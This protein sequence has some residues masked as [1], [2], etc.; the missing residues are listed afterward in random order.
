[1]MGSMLKEDLVVLFD[2]IE[3]PRIERSKKYPIGEIIF[4]V[5]FAALLGVES[6]RGTALLGSERID[7]LRK[8]FPF[9]NG[10]P[11]HQTI[12]RVFSI[13]KPKSFEQFFNAWSANL[14]GSNNGK[15]I[16]FDGKCLRGSYDKN[17]GQK[18]LHILNACAVEN[19]ITLA[20]IEVDEKTN[21]ITAVPDMI[22]A[23]NI[24]GAMISVDALNTQKNIAEK[25]ID[26]GAN[27]TLALKGNHKNLNEDVSLLFDTTEIDLLEKKDEHFEGCEKEHG[28]ITTRIYDVIPVD[29]NNL[30]LSLNWKGLKSV[31]RVKT[32]TLKNEKETSETRY[33]LL[34]YNGAK[35]FAKAARGHWGIENKLHWS[36]DVVYSEDESRK[37]AD[38]APRNYSLIRKFALNICRTFK[39]KLSVP[40]FHIKNASNFDFFHSVLLRSGFKPLAV[41]T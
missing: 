3:D 13:L 26:S 6:W 28:R 7:L 31:G 34:S 14:H 25:I 23:L 9:I 1:M 8:F 38:Y 41:L 12:G 24:K 37:R 16:A 19:G 32:T 15:Q 10:V 17:K 20:Q 22:D 40:L 5:I 18:A 39:E 33:F 36:L 21:E 35:E 29:L 11:S 4:V 27:Y 30:K 2:E